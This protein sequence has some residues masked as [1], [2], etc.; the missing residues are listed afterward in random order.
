MYNMLWAHS[1]L[2]ISQIGGSGAGFG[3]RAGKS[4]MR[5]GNLALPWSDSIL[6][7]AR[8]LAMYNMLSLQGSARF[9]SRILLLPARG[10]NP[11][12]D[13]PIWE[14]YNMLWAHSILYTGRG[15]PEAPFWWWGG[16]GGETSQK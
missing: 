16:R 1:I 10:P 5:E 8:Y 13:P 14:M 12:P 9:P 3:P 4:N 6:Y 15:L 2:Y 7:M 11:A